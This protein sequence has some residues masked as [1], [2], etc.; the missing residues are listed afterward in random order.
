MTLTGNN[1]ACAHV[2]SNFEKQA[3]FD[4]ALAVE[5]HRR[6]H[7]AYP[8]TL[9]ALAPEFLDAAP[10]SIIDG[11]PFAYE[12]GDGLVETL[13]QRHKPWQKRETYVFDGFR[14]R[15]STHKRDSDTQWTRQNSIPVPF[16]APQ[17]SGKKAKNRQ[18]SP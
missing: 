11:A 5:L 3:L 1:A 9:A 14:I 12:H 16:D 4:A 13:H 10:A 6:K 15:G 17:S 2:F 7:G 8:D 18:K